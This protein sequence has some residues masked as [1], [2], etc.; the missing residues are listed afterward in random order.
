MERPL[1]TVIVI[2][3]TRTYCAAPVM[4]SRIKKVTHSFR[5]SF[6]LA[7]PPFRSSDKAFTLCQ[8]I[9]RVLPRYLK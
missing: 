4:S 7:R 1:P 2:H 9:R 5:S 3:C 6:W 8:A